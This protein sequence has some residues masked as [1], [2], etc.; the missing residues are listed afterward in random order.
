MN[1]IT[2]IMYKMK[3]T[4]EFHPG[5]FGRFQFVGGKDADVLVF[6][7]V[8]DDR[9]LFAVGMNDVIDFNPATDKVVNTDAFK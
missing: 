1:L 5:R 7:D 9:L 4:Q 2:G 6:S 3:D 8:N